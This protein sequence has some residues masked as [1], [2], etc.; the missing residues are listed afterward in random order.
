LYFDR[1][2]QHDARR[3]I[4]PYSPRV[5]QTGCDLTRSRSTV[6]WPLLADGAW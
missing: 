6:G 3:A 5:K 1:D 2:S 4:R